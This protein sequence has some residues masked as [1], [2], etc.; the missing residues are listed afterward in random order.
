MEHIFNEGDT[1]EACDTPDDS[2]IS[3]IPHHE[4]YHP[5][6]SEKIRVVFNCSAKFRD[7]SL[8]D[9]LLTGSDLINAL[10]GVLC[11]FCEH[12][13]VLTCGIQRMFHH[14][15]VSPRDRDFLRFF[16][17]ENRD[18]KTKPKEYRIQVH[19]FGPSS[20]PG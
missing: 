15:H 2:S 13:I 9:H 16:W 12:H 7:T 18:T 20:S 3:Y 8:N 19:I 10:P 14:F 1:E 17:W 11:R 5:R 6:K 4:V